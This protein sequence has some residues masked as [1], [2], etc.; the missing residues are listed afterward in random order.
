MYTIPEVAARLNKTRA[1]I[2]AL[3]KDL[4]VMDAAAFALAREAALPI[5]VFSIRE[6]GAIAS[7]AKGEGRV[8]IV[9][10]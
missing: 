1:H 2:W 10:P 9:A 7:A 5:I 8:T 6:A 4:K 3:A